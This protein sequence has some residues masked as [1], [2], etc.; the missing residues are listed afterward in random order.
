MVTWHNAS[1]SEERKAKFREK[2]RTLLP[3]TWL[4]IVHPG[5]YMA[6][7]R[8]TVELLC[9]AQ[10]K[11]IIRQRG[12]HLLSFADLWQRKFGTQPGSQ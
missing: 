4:F 7:Q 11:E 6:Q 9:S 3:G 5:L 2:I 12:I 10:V 1:V 8:G